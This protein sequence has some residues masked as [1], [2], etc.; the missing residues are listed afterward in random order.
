MAKDYYS[1]LGIPKGASADEIKKAYRKLAHRHHP[2]KTGGDDLRFKEINEAYYVLSDEGRRSSYD[3]FGVGVGGGQG[4]P[5]FSIFTE[6]FDGWFADIMSEFFGGGVHEAQSRGRDIAVGLTITLEQVAT[7]MKEDLIVTRWVM[8]DRCKGKG[9]EPGTSL[10]TCGVCSGAGKL[11]RVEQTF[12]GA[13]TRVVR[14][15]TCSGAGEIPETPCTTC[16]GSGRIRRQDRVP[17]TLP[18]GLEDGETFV[19]ERGGDV[20]VAPHAGKSGSLYVTVHVASHNR[21][22]RE[23]DDLWADEEISFLTLVRGGSIAIKTLDESSVRLK[24]PQGTASGK[25]FRISGKGLPRRRRSLHRGSRGDLYV[26]VHARVPQKPSKKF[27]DALDI[28]GEEL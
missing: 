28:L 21:F 5:D 25:V 18:A 9:G 10:K 7:G 20:P 27:L 3:K 15:P 13:M 11:H 23:G 17:V 16:R 19:I 14:C 1:I 6:G 2:D 26:T 12:F 4:A 8:C 22:R 24:I